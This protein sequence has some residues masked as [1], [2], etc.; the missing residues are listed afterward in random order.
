[1]P[2]G[3]TSYMDLGDFSTGDVTSLIL[4]GAVKFC[5]RPPAAD[6]KWVLIA[7]DTGEIRVFNEAGLHQPAYDIDLGW[8]PS[9]VSLN[10]ETPP[11]ILIRRH[12]NLGIY[13]YISGSEDWNVTGITSMVEALI[14]DGYVH[15]LLRTEVAAT[16][17]AQWR[18]LVDGSLTT[19][20]TGGPFKRAAGLAVTE[21]GTLVY[22]LS[23]HESQSR[24]YILKDDRVTGRSWSVNWISTANPGNASMMNK[25]S[26]DGSIVISR[27]Y[28][29]GFPRYSVRLSGALGALLYGTTTGTV[30]PIIAIN[31]AGTRA[32]YVLT[33]A[34]HKL[35]DVGAHTQVALGAS[36]AVDDHS[37]D[38]TDDPY[39]IC[40]LGN[41]DI[42][43]YND[44]LALKATI[45]YG[46][47]NSP[48]AVVRNLT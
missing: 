17:G 27:H 11:K 18:S 33:N 16:C 42:E 19:G 47:S 20:V 26:A 10:N 8:A 6:P 7:S 23:Y 28:N 31:P 39:F 4:T 36:R 44:A 9:Q 5:V 40:S 38:V 41:G 21:A 14:S 43:I 3:Q 35:T 34:L 29:P 24:C 13:L 15:T 48:V 12:S 46:L 22:W 32:A 1:M 30:K 25:C 2:R 37:T 45:A